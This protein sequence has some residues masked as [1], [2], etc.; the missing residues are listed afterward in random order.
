[1]KAV[2]GIRAHLFRIKTFQSYSD[3]SCQYMF[4]KDELPI[5][6]AIHKTLYK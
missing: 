5:E 1:M 4:L 3:K 6:F 2:E